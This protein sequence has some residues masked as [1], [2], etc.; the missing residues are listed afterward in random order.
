VINFSRIQNMQDVSNS[1]ICRLWEYRKTVMLPGML[2]THIALLLAIEKP[3]SCAIHFV[4]LLQSSLCQAYTG[5]ECH[6]RV[7]RTHSCC[8]GPGFKYRP[9]DRPSLHIFV[10]FLQSNIGTVLL[11]RPAVL[12]PLPFQLIIH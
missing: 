2:Y 9:Q 6:F 7:G 4:M 10:V 11:I 5:T 12:L 3:Y 8:G 1:I